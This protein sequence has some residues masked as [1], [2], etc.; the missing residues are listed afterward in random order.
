VWRW[1]WWWQAVR[2]FFRSIALAGDQSLQDILRLLTLW[3][4]HGAQ[5]EVEAALSDGFNRISIDTW[6]SVIPQ[7]IARIH[8]SH[9]PVR[10]LIHEL[11]CKIGAAHPQALVYPLTVASKSTSAARKAAAVSV[12]SHMRTHSPGLVEQAMTVSRELIRVA[13]LWHEMWHEALEEA[14]RLYFGQ[15]NVDGMFAVLAPLH[16]M[17]NKGPQTLREVAFQQA[18]GRDLQEAHEWC[19]KYLRSNKESD[20]N[21]A[22]DLYCTVFRKINKQLSQLTDLGMCDV[23]ECELCCVL[24]CVF[25]GVPL[26]AAL[27]EQMCACFCLL[28]FFFF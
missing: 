25:V 2:G 5:P 16:R 13:I 7:I 18:F 15:R 24:W 27:L 22:W 9:L 10:R 14:S 4:A 23:V 17:M 6:L 3:F 11:L 19:H 26:A 12:V 28:F 20:L 8:T 1:W 21:Q